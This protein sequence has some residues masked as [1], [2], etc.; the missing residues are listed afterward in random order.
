MKA[1]AKCLRLKFGLRKVPELRL[2]TPDN[3]KETV[4][5]P[6]GRCHDVFNLPPLKNYCLV[7]EL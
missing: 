6:S 1:D 3:E 4:L 5:V 7:Y 2:K